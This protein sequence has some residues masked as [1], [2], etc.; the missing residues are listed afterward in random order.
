MMTSESPTN[1][2]ESVQT[3]SEIDSARSSFR[4]RVDSL[5]QG[6]GDEALQD[7]RPF[8]IDDEKMPYSYAELLAHLALHERGHHGDITDPL[9]AA[10]V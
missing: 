1:V 7:V 10:S 6:L 9:L 5:L 8:T 2:A 3:L 4:T